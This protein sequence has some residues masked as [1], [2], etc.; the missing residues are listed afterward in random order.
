LELIMK[1]ASPFLTVV[2]IFAMRLLI[3]T[4]VNAGCFQTYQ[5]TILN[6]CAPMELLDRVVCNLDAAVELTACVRRS[7]F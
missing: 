7:L 1:K 6:T 2:M 3:A 5:K 4:D